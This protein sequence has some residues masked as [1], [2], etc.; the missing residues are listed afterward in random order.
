MKMPRMP[1]IDKAT[2]ETS[3]DPGDLD[4][5][6]CAACCNYRI[7]TDALV[8]L[9]SAANDLYTAK[10]STRNGVVDDYCVN[11]LRQIQY[12]MHA[13]VDGCPSS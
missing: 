3:S 2:S 10:N 4:E 7:D 12:A 9:A 1:K 5:A 8:S 11:A 6:D 13:A